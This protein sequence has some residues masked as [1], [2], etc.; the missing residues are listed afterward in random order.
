MTDTQRKSLEHKATLLKAAL[1]KSP[2]DGG[3]TDWSSLWKGLQDDEALLIMLMNSAPPVNGPYPTPDTP[4]N[5]EYGWALYFLN[6][7]APVWLQT[8]L[9]TKLG[10]PR[11][12]ITSADWTAWDKI[13]S[14]T[15]ICLGDGSLV[16]TQ[17]YAVMDVEWSLALIDYL[18]LEIGV[19]HKAPFSTNPNS[20]TIKTSSQ[21]SLSIAVIGDWG[22]G[23]Y[24][25]GPSPNSP[26]TQV[27]TAIKNLAPDIVIHLGDVYY[28]GTKNGLAPGDGEEQSN[29]VDA[30]QYKAHLGNFTLNSNHEM[31]NG[32]QGYYKVALASDIFAPYHTGPKSNQPTS[33]FSIA[34]GDYV[35]IGLDSAYYATSMFMDGRITDA[36]Q[37]AFIKTASAGK[38]VILFTHH[39]PIDTLGN[40]TNALWTDVTS[41][42]ALN[43]VPAMWYWGHIHNGM[44][45]SESAVTGKG[46]LARCLGNGAIPIGTGRW[47][48]NNNIS[49][50]T[51][52]PLN[53]GTVNNSLRVK[54]GFALITIKDNVITERW[55]DQSGKE[56][57]RSVP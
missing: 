14:T 53:D 7:D 22:T 16:S 32:A 24:P 25:D 26:S 57:W 39:N 35:L 17:K 37:P 45:Y 47:L 2:A 8:F 48:K 10:M 28:A 13:W 50:F 42:N 56:C 52:T 3:A 30:W 51:N 19:E 34:Y 38:K 4:G 12:T 29:L 31:Y 11:T 36:Y 41:A 54:N 40:T 6:V 44:V 55:Y 27:M 49:Y 46:T 1:E 20:I 15:G 18:L 9:R 5:I 21:P 33:Y 23:N 43:G